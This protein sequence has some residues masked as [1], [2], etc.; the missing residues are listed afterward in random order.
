MC[1]GVKPTPPP[2]QSPTVSPTISD[3]PSVSVLVGGGGGAKINFLFMQIK[4]NKYFLGVYLFFIR[5]LLFLHMT[6]LKQGKDRTLAREA[7]L[8]HPPK[9][10]KATVANLV[11]A[12]QR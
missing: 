1:Y 3:S 12:A 5:L 6:V 2:T 4:K 11:K 7:S 9:G 8:N 10:L